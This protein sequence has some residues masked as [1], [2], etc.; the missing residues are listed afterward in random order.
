[1]GKKYRNSLFAEEEKVQE[2]PQGQE[3]GLAFMWRTVCNA[4]LLSLAC[5][6]LLAVVYPGTRRLLLELLWQLWQEFR[7]LWQ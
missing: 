5:I 6:G 2:K 7:V 4:L 1:M 3:S